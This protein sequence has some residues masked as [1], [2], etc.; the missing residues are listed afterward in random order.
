M[1]PYNEDD[2][3]EHE[4]ESVRALRS[5]DFATNYLRRSSVA[6]IRRRTPPPLDAIDG[7]L[8]DYNAVVAALRAQGLT[9][10]LSGDEAEH[11]FTLGFALEQLHRNFRD[12]ARCVSSAKIGDMAS[13]AADPAKAPD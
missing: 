3:G 1:P 6:L 9:R 7:A 5:P 8:G 10:A 2:D 12:L 4:P 13:A 11:F